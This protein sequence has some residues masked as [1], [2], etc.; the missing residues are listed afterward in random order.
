MSQSFIFINTF[1]ARGH[2]IVISDLAASNFYELEGIKH[3]S[4][5]NRCQ[6]LVVCF[7]CTYNFGPLSSKAYEV[8]ELNFYFYSTKSSSKTCT[9]QNYFRNSFV[10]SSNT[11][12][13]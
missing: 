13:K 1:A 11:H 12:S 2:T 8:H 5:E 7:A 3:A 4:T 6:I 10:L 9:C